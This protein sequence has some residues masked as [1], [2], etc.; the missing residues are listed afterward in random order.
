MSPWVPCSSLAHH[1]H[2]V[3]APGGARLAL[4]VSP[5]EKDPLNPDSCLPPR[6]LLSDGSSV[7][8][9]AIISPAVLSA[10]FPSSSMV[11]G[12]QMQRGRQNAGL[13]EAKP[14]AK[15]QPVEFLTLQLTGQLRGQSV[16]G[17]RGF[18]G[19]RGGERAARRHVGGPGRI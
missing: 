14:G 12:F 16:G 17:W 2:S 8:S 15:S 10:G 6:R 13:T 11:C 5:D 9:T 18:G 4:T 7:C 3:P 19:V 1:G